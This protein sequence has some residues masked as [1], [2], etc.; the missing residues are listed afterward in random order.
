MLTPWTRGGEPVTSA[1]V[2][3]ELTADVGEGPS[4]DA[5]TQTL[6]FVDISRGFIYRFDPTTDQLTRTAFGQEVRAAIPTDTGGMVVAARRGIYL[7][8]TDGSAPQMLVP[9]D[10]DD[11]SIRLN[12]AKCDPAGRLWVGSMAFDFTPG[13]ASLYR[14][15]VA[16]ATAARALTGLTIANGMGWSPDAAT[17]YFID[18][19]PG[20]VRAFDYDIDTGN[21]SGERLVV[22]TPDSGFPDGMTMDDE[23]A[24]WVAYYGAGEVRRFDPSGH[25]TDTVSL[26]VT[27]VTSCCFGG[28][29]LDTLFVTSAA[30]ELGP[31]DLADQPLAGSTFACSP[32][33]R[34]AATTAFMVGDTGFEPVTPRV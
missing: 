8:E 26:P 17:M 24:L 12:D 2:A 9:I 34:G 7:S 14:I 10:A 11:D 27:Q 33:V 19:G 28:A 23:G 18:S 5:L 29:D 22:G 15:D 16:T 3:V 21:I 30:Y 1:E 31:A 13:A 4:W 25:R 20:T 32:G 6:L